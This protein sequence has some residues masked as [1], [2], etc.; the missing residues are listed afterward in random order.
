VNDYP[1]GDS[2]GGI[3]PYEQDPE[4]RIVVTYSTINGN[5]FGGYGE[6]VLGTQGTIVLEREQDV[7]LFAKE[8]ASTRIE[9]KDD[10]GGASTMSYETGGAATATRT[11]AAAGPVSRG[12]TE[13]IEHWAYC[14]RAN[15]PEVR[16]RCHPQVALGDAV[17]ALTARHAM[18]QASQ[19]KGGYLQFQEDWF[20]YH[21]DATPDGSEVKQEMENLGGMA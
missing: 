13:E 6:V 5:G 18:N 17:M 3:P 21:N 16:P 11:A 1:P 10:A 12:Y 4:K 8:G 14:I 15:N 2:K 20:D 19:G 9:V 7:L